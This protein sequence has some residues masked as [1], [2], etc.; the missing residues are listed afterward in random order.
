MGRNAAEAVMED[1]EH[2]P[3]PR[4]DVLLRL[5]ANEAVETALTINEVQEAVEKR[6]GG[7]SSS[8]ARQSAGLG[9]PSLTYNVGPACFSPGFPCSPT[10][11]Q[12]F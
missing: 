4:S 10:W 12:A 6:E 5:F 1:R 3:P 11:T 7:L 2:C 8:A 9:A